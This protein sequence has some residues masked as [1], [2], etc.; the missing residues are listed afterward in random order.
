MATQKPESTDEPRIIEENELWQQYKEWIIGGIV[1]VGVALAGLGYWMLDQESRNTAA[2]ELYGKAVD[3]ED[4]QAIIA[5]YPSSGEA[6]LS[7][8]DLAKMA[9]EAEDYDTAL[10][11]YNSFV[12]SFPRHPIRPAA[13]YAKGRALEAL[14]KTQEAYD[15]YSTLT[16]QEPKHAYRTAAAVRMATIHK[17]KGEIEKARALLDDII[18]NTVGSV[19]AELE[20]QQML[21]NLPSVPKTSRELPTEAKDESTEAPASE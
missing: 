19:Y 12:Q 3:K 11:H 5:K 10:G 17:D 4:Y 2:A 1:V 14:G 20:A 15:W 6:A 16:N 13:D 21:K 8:L 18:S 9:L 7:R